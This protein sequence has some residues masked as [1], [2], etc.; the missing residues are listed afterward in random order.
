[1]I[2][3]SQML[4]KIS[5]RNLVEFILRSGDIDNRRS[6]S[7]DVDAMREGA[8]I[9]KK[10]QNRMGPE[11]TPEVGMRLV[12]P[13]ERYD[14]QLEG[15]A[16][17]VIEKEGEITIID[18]IKGVYQDLDRIKEPIPVHL[19]QAKCYAY[20]Y[21]LD[22]QESF[23]QVQM[24][25]VN[26]ES[27]EI[28]QFQ[29]T[30]T[31]EDLDQWFHQLILSY[32]K[33]T[34]FQYD[35]SIT[36]RGSIKGIEFPF[37]Y[38]KGQREL[39]RDS[40]RTIARKKILFLQAPTGTGKTISTIFPAV[41]AVGEGLGE[42]IFY[43]TAKTITAS[44]AMDTFALLKEHGY[45]SKL[46]QI[47]AKE[48]LC[49]LEEM[50]CNPDACPYAKG[51]FDRI[52]DAVYEFLQEEDNFHRERILEQAK[53]HMVCPF[54]LCLDTSSWCDDIVCDYNYAFDPRVKLKRFF[55][56]GVGGDYLFLVDEAH[57]LV[58][59][60]REMYSA[61]LYKEDF[62][63]ARS[64]MKHYAKNIE[65]ALTKCNTILLRYKREC[66]D[67]VVMD[68]TA[69][70][71]LALSNL[72]SKI[73]KFLTKNIEFKEK[74]EFLDFYFS[75][76]QFIEIYDRVDEK[77]VIYSEHEEASGRFK[78]K[79]F[80]VDPSRNLQ[81]CLNKARSCILMSATLLPIHYYKSLLSTKTDNYAIYADSSFSTE[82][83]L[84]AI[85]ND[86]SS[87]YTRR[88]QEEYQRIASY[89]K[90]AVEAKA[91]NYMVFLPSYRMM[92]EVYDAFLEFRLS[93]VETM[94]Q[95]TGMVEKERED[96]LKSFAS[97]RE[98][99]L[100]G[101][102]VLGGIFG[103]GIDL[104]EDRLIGTIVVGTGIP[105]IG[106]ERELLKKY[107]DEQNGHGF[108][109]AYRYPG[110]NKVQQAAGRVIRTTSD[111]GIILLLDDRFLQYENR[112]TF[113]REWQE[114][115]ICQLSNIQNKMEEFWKNMSI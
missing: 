21:A 48:K 93:G 97:E 37:P 100:V 6:T 84:L 74:K 33:W 108:D 87:K 68:T 22:N 67:Y 78:L 103:E 43:L 90:M 47:T 66:D 88:T 12:I 98:E 60:A 56:D 65:K 89:I 24:T 71:V 77:Y 36:H 81:E 114:F 112:K 41:K 40:Y 28:K 111:R 18:E 44:V 49:P 63:E 17:G 46:I 69:D 105:Q 10:I 23:M 14:I 94:A 32:K 31:R 35:W 80:C 38:R 73:E 83:R 4:I 8:R 106:H 57:N 85:G 101:F 26:I 5:V 39:V 107:F 16:D 102:C 64:Y 109:Y 76:R 7:A 2:E 58:E 54:E 75:V 9:H 19:A 91:G 45:R 96:F 55:A 99:S 72:A 104:T 82:Q 51:H 42:K 113:P 20:M 70:L 11:Y 53:K 3:E 25:Y 50:E 1:M 61:E 29:E 115:E 15:R 79:L 92:E 59:R 95:R 52:N 86:V 34:D 110:M 27:E 30:Y 62:L 13:G